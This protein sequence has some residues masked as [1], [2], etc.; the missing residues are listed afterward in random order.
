MK[1]KL[2]VNFRHSFITDSAFYMNMNFFKPISENKS[3]PFGYRKICSTLLSVS[4]VLLATLDSCSG[5]PE[6]ENKFTDDLKQKSEAVKVIA[7]GGT[8]AEGTSAKLDRNHDCF[9][10]GTTEM[11][12]VRNTQTWWAI[13]GRILED[14]AE[15]EVE[16]I[17]AGAAGNTAAIGA[18]RLEDDVLSH[19]PDYVLL[20]FGMDDALAGVQPDKFQDDLEKIVTRIEAEKVNVVLLTPPPISKR[21][22]INCSM[23]ELR[24]RQSNLS[25]LVQV[26]RDLA[27]EK[28]LSLIDFHQFF[29]ANRLAYD[30]LFEGWLPDAV[31]QSAMAPFVA[32]EL[33]PVMGVDN[34]PNP[35][36]CDYRKVYS[37]AGNPLTQHNGFTDLTYFKGEYFLV[38]RSGR[39][40]KVP[41]HTTSRSEVIV[42]LRSGDG[43]AWHIDAVLKKE[44]LDNRDPKFLQAD[45]WLKVYVPCTKTSDSPDDHP[46]RITYGFERLSQGR[47]SEP[48]PCAQCILWRPR[49]WR[50]EFVSAGYPW[51]IK[52]NDQELP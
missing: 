51:R 1:L 42:I 22:T 6:E 43:I 19:S 52:K 33:L 2:E 18:V 7:F 21:M 41:E 25:G 26:I 16:V 45:G 17:G 23:N 5:T 40:H 8:V 50:G 35:T 34:Y 3:L 44:G 29:L 46:K 15:G 12:M 39:F 11:I 37:D 27:K 14:W 20:M 47:W 13:L 31:A 49:E 36:L 4:I 24:Q 9:R 38:F 48:F 10:W 28:S 30:H 32:G